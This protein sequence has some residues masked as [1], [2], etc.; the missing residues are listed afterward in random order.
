MPV[1]RRYACEPGA[2][3]T[4]LLLPKKVDLVLTGHEHIYQRTKQLALGAGC[5]SLADRVLQRRLRQD[6]D[7]ALT[8]GAG[9]RLRHRRHRRRRP[10]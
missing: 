8:A 10:A 1:D 6:T 7:N 9:T 3:L 2:D 5:T 4:N